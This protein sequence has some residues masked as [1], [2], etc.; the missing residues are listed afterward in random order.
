MLSRTLAA[1]AFA[2]PAHAADRAT[3]DRCEHRLSACHDECRAQKTSAQCNAACTTS[4]CDGI[5]WT[6]TYQEF[7]DRQ[8]E[9]H[10]EIYTGFQGLDKVRK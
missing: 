5:S 1:L 2:I 6:E 3:L 10:A 9:Y 7:A 8:I 4:L